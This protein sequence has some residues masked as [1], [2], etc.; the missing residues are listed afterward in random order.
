VVCVPCVGWGV[1]QVRPAD[2]HTDRENKLFIGMLPKTVDDNRLEALFSPFGRIKEIHII[3]G[4][5]VR[6]SRGY[7][8]GDC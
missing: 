2:V 5:E 6:P 4:P 8:H 7:L 3:R 1:G